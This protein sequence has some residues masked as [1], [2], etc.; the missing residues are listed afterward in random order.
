M[1]VM[2]LCLALGPVACGD[3]D[4]DGDK[5]GDGDNGGDGDGSADNVAACNSWKDAVSCEGADLSILNQ[6]DCSTYNM[7]ACDISAYFDCLTENTKCNGSAL[8]VSGWTGCQNLI[9]CQ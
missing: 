5:G 4:D 7:Y 1:A 6:L 9:D 8:D 3:D 2:A